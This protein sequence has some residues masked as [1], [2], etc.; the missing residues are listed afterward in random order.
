MPNA[1]ADIVQ[2]KIDYLFD[3]SSLPLLNE[4]R[5]HENKASQATCNRKK[6]KAKHGVFASAKSHNMPAEYGLRAHFDIYTG[7]TPLLNHVTQLLKSMIQAGPSWDSNNW[8]C[9][10][11]SAF[12]VLLNAYCLM[13]EALRNIWLVKC[14][15]AD[16]LVTLL[17]IAKIQTLS[18]MDTAMYNVLRDTWRDAL[19]TC[20]GHCSCQVWASLSIYLCFT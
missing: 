16:N 17:S 5:T 9:A 19:S 10:Y 4:K 12:M 11:D 2:T 8:S 18:S 7:G 13:N 6:A 14:N 15:D 3:E 20:D 1:E